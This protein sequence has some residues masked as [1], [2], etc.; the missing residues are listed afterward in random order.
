[1]DVKSGP[2]SKTLKVMDANLSGF[3]VYNVPIAH[4]HMPAMRACALTSGHV[5]AAHKRIDTSAPKLQ[6]VSC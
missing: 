2:I 4:A 5:S 3:T 1:M 6:D